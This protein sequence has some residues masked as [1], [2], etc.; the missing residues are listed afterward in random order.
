[1]LAAAVFFL[2]LHG[3][4]LVRAFWPSALPSE[5][6][7]RARFGRPRDFT[8][9]VSA[10]HPRQKFGGFFYFSH[11]ARSFCSAGCPATPSYLT[12][13]WTASYELRRREGGACGCA[14]GWHAWPRGNRVQNR[15]R[16]RGHHP[17][18]Q[19]CSAPERLLIRI[20]RK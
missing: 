10:V 3:I 16:G 11:S 20:W 6:L 1:V 5:L 18:P 14:A 7:A 9:H 17:L 13:T 4:V 15:L 8:V 2:Y 12:G 19:T